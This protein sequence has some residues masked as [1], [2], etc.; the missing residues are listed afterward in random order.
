MR[1]L[2]L[3]IL[4]LVTSYYANCQWVRLDSLSKCVFCITSKIGNLYAGTTYGGVFISQDEGLTWSQINNGLTNTNVRSILV[5]GSKLFA[6]TEGGVFVSLN[7]GANWSS[8]NNGLISHEVFCLIAK[9]SSIYAAT[10]GGGIYVSEN[11][12]N[13][14]TSRNNGLGNLF[15]E[16]I[17]LSGNDIYAGTDEGVY[18]SHNGGANWLEKNAG[19]PNNPWGSLCSIESF[20]QNNVGVYASA[21]SAGI[22]KSV[23]GGESW[24]IL[25]TLN[26]YIEVS[27]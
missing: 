15:V 21:T 9:D 10:R 5:K 7:N 25:N 3:G 27:I 23:D 26:Y 11:N 22:I 17:Y 12:G 8:V 20:T 4:L 6:G 16:T 1:K 18:I 13:N 24:S 19:I 2:I 14:W